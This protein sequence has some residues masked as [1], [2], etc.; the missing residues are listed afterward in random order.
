MF[1]DINV[2]E[3][4]VYLVLAQNEEGDSL[5]GIFTDG[6]TGGSDSA[7]GFRSGNVLARTTAMMG[8]LFLAISFG[9]ALLN[10]RF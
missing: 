2:V 7:F 3:R 1:T 9:L 10:R 6:F 5:E 8:A 4:W